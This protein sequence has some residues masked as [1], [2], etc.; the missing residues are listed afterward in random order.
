[1][2]ALVTTGPSILYAST[3][4][5]AL[6][7]LGV[8][9]GQKLQRWLGIAG[10]TN[11][12]EWFVTAAALGIGAL[13]FVPFALGATGLLAVG[14]LRIA[15][16][17]VVLLLS[18]ELVRVGMR[19]L[20]GVRAHAKPS[21]WVL[22][23]VAV[24]APAVLA[25]FFVALT[26]TLDADGLGYHLTVPKRWLENGSLCYLPTYPYSNTPMGVEMLFTIALAVAGDAAAKTLHFTLGILGALG[27]YAA[28]KRLSTV[29]VG[30]TA[31]MLFLVGPTG[32]SD[33]L[34]WAYLEG[35]T[36]FAMIASAV[37]W[38]VWFK[39]RQRGW[40]ECA[41]ILA[42]FGVSFKLTAALFP[43]ALSVL[44]IGVLGDPAT[45]ER[46]LAPDPLRLAVRL[47]VLTAVPVLPWLTRSLLVTG[48]PFF[49]LFAGLIP[50][51]D[52]SPGIAKKFEEYNRYL[53][54]ASRQLST[55]GLH[56]RKL[57]LAAVAVVVAALSAVAFV[58]LRS[59]V[60]RSATIALAI[61]VLVQLGAVGLYARYWIPML[62]VLQLPLLIAIA[63]IL[64]WRWVQIGL[65][66]LATL[67]SLTRARHTIG[68][69]GAGAAELAR[70][71]FGA[72]GQGEFLSQHMPLYPIY[73]RANRTLPADARIVLS[74]YC[75]GFYLD[76]TTYCAEFVQDSLRL[77]VWSAFMEDIRRLGVTHIVTPTAVVAGQGPIADSGG[78]VSDIFRT[79]QNDFVG[80]LLRDSGHLLVTASDEGLYALSP[81]PR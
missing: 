1:M 17:G 52:L 76:R 42:G 9:L 48:N 50:S 4:A 65:L 37:A 60:A 77:T 3:F 78:S 59:R 55:W 44:T 32:V 81:L 29:A 8:A 6:L 63:P 68:A 47:S 24:L 39:D 23:C 75:G 46:T 53:L 54:W 73:E 19:T 26:P 27:L 80:R 2:P 22:A 14:A 31:A 13:Q 20:R 51:R 5:V 67:S 45:R 62:A 71:A 70:T 30:A 57:L 79:Q 33:L 43:I 21:A 66:A 74:T 49:P 15:M 61:T 34:G 10:T 16:A 58:R 25:A 41:F 11:E 7:W 18:P 72:E 56:E 12:I 35:A 64:S 28:G 38:S 40:L 69:T 36:A